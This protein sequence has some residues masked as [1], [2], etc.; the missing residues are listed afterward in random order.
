M[1][2][3]RHV[4]QDKS[5]I[6]KQSSMTPAAPPPTPVCQRALHT[7]THHELRTAAAMSTALAGRGRK[8]VLLHDL[9]TAFMEDVISAMAGRWYEFR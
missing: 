2:R 9:Y 4:S 7:I 8:I 5:P 6:D 3:I 1:E